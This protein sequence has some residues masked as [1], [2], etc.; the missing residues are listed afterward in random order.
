[1]N[2][3][4]IKQA[5]STRTPEETTYLDWLQRT[6]HPVLA[7]LR[8]L[9]NE[10][11]QNKIQTV[12]SSTTL[13]LQTDVILVDATSG[14]VTITPPTA[15][16]WE[17]RIIVIK[18]D[19]SANAVTVVGVNTGTL[20][21]QYSGAEMICDGTIY[22]VLT[23]GSAVA[24]DITI[25]PFTISTDQ[26]SYAPTGWSGA[27]YVLLNPTIQTLYLNSFDANV[28]VKRKTILNVATS[29]SDIR[30]RN[31]SHIETVAANRVLLRK[32]NHVYLIAQ[33]SVDIWYDDVSLRWRPI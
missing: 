32:A 13:E 12:T 29:D 18:T 9:T 26:T 8:A 31:D 16:L 14:P 1:M 10:L 28:T 33:D 15:A 22:Y 3:P 21:S 4:P 5:V 17:R 2:S 7:G 23:F 25:G 19:A 27:R 20:S 6:A 11:S 30:I 24:A